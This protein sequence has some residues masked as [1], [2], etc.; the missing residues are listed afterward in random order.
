MIPMF[1]ILFGTVAL[2]FVIDGAASALTAHRTVC[3]PCTEA[4]CDATAE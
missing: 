3:T 1:L 4:K 2:A